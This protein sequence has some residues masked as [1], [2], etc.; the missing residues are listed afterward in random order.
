VGTAAQTDPDLILRAM[1]SG[2]HEFLVYPPEPTELAAAV[3]R[4]LRRTH[5]EGKAGTTVAVFSAKGGLGTTSVAVNLAFGLAK[6]RPNGRV[7]LLD[8]VA[9]GGD[10]RVMLNLR[11][12]YDIGDLVKKM[13]QL[14]AELLH[15]ML[16]PCEGGVWVLPSAEDEEAVEGLDAPATTAVIEN[17]RG[18]FAYTV[19]DCEHHMG[20]R[21]LAALDIADRVLVVTQLSV[22]AL[23]STQRTLSLCRRLGYSDEKVV[24]VVNRHQSADVVSVADAAQVLKRSVFFALPND[25]QTLAAALTRGV[26]VLTHAASS[27]IAA[28]YGALATKLTGDQANGNGKK[29]GTSG[30]SRLGRIF[31]IGRK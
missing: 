11:P 22:A 3:D 25:Y 20:E 12:T 6:G 7:A 18:Q 19:V 23:R 4:L 30:G 14:D 26:P 8:L 21:T 1:R 10:V 24:V 13:D 2:V 5:S 27:P 9:S 31:S 15:S 28:S 29:N 16:T 17:L